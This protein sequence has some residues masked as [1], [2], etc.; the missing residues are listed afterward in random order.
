MIFFEYSHL[1]VSLFLNFCLHVEA[2]S[3]VINQCNPF[4]ELVVSNKQTNLSTWLNLKQKTF[5]ECGLCLADDE[6]E[7]VSKAF[8]MLLLLSG[9]TMLFQLTTCI[10][11]ENHGRY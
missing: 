11:V 3:I 4:S 2:K 7:N 1:I 9:L 10:E 6:K 5:I 8:E